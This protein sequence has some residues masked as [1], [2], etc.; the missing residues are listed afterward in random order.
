MSE[1]ANDAY[2]VPEPVEPAALMAFHKLTGVATGDSEGSSIRFQ[3]GDST[4]RVCHVWTL[5]ETLLE[6]GLIK[7]DE[8]LLSE[9]LLD[10]SRGRVD[11]YLS[12][13]GTELLRLARKEQQR[14]AARGEKGGVFLTLLVELP[15]DA[16]RDIE[17]DLFPGQVF[18]VVTNHPGG[19]STAEVLDM[20]R[21]AI[22]HVLMLLPAVVGMTRPE[23]EARFI[24]RG[25]QGSGVLDPLIERA[26]KEAGTIVGLIAVQ[27]ARLAHYLEQNSRMPR[28]LWDPE[29]R[30]QSFTDLLDRLDKDLPPKLNAISNQIE[31]TDFGLE[32]AA[33]I[34]SGIPVL[35]EIID[36][37]LSTWHAV[38]SVIT[39]V[40]DAISSSLD[41]ARESLETIIGYVSGLWDGVM[42][43]LIGL[44][45]MGALLLQ[46]IGAFLIASHDLTRV[47]AVLREF[48]DEVIQALARVDWV[49]FWGRFASEILPLIIDLLKKK[50]TAFID[51]A[52][53]HSAVAG[54][55]FGYL[56]Y[57]VIEFFMPPLKFGK[58]AQEAR[59]LR[60]AAS[61]RF[62]A[63]VAA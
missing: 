21:P 52:T 17:E 29:Q 45:E 61:A 31:A 30:P 23:F 56:V 25:D 1:A 12:R 62:F 37:M 60:A 47:R 8:D 38:Q 35:N 54:Y 51:E 43:A 53:R 26:A 6:D 58:I 59:L 57:T 33:R 44:L 36:F 40:L 49:V 39:S 63:K 14:Y 50:G 10:L 27:V 34:T 48:T 16:S 3:P 22:A 42:E 20:V 5:T 19:L 9:L 13:S 18:E 2:V 24:R 11:I 15:G 55:Y 32:S 41:D 4:D 46:V 7:T 28:E